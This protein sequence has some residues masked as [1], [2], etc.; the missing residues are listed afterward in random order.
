MLYQ[1]ANPFKVD[2][3]DSFEKGFEL[4]FV[5]KFAFLLFSRFLNLNKICIYCLFYFLATLI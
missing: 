5:G 3:E 4:K 2:Q 1:L